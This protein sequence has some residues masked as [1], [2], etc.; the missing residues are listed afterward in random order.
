M[1]SDIELFDNKGLLEFSEKDEQGNFHF[2]ITELLKKSKNNC[3]N[4]KSILII[5]IGK[6][7]EMKRLKKELHKKVRIPRLLI[8]ILL[9]TDF[10][11]NSGWLVNFISIVSLLKKQLMKSMKL[12]CHKKNR[13]V[14]K[15]II[16]Y[17]K[18]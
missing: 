18:K 5:L 7:T 1:I 12:I 3:K 2:I 9:Q 13:V 16:F 15:E 4:I 14:M 17:V 11:T 6:L 10:Q 8:G